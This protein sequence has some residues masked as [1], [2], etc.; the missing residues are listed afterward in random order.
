MNYKSLESTLGGQG[1]PLHIQ[2][3]NGKPRG[4]Q[5]KY[6]YYNSFTSRHHTISSKM[7]KR[8]SHSVPHGNQTSA[9]ATHAAYPSEIAHAAHA[10]HTANDAHPA[11]AS[12]HAADAAVGYVNLEETEAEDIRSNRT[13]QHHIDEGQCY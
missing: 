7:R 4:N 11:R 3:G 9:E 8:S 12:D 13:G 6:N 5:V 10:A 2:H 1:L